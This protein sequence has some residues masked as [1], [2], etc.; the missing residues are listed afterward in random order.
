MMHL[1]H[2]VMEGAALVIDATA[3]AIM[4]W[5]FIVA[6]FAFVKSSFGG[7]AGDRVMGLQMARCE[8]SV[9]LVF[10]L[11]LLIISDLLQTVVSRTLEDL[12]FLAA[13][14]FIRT[15]IGY[16]LNQEIQE[17]GSELAE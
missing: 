5:G 3:S 12:W 2:T 11:E 16:F 1:F 14:V 13:L 6:V 10:G 9:K 7:V 4:V 17:M 15:I 8:L